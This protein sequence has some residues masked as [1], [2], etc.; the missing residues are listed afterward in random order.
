VLIA[1][2]TVDS[3]NAVGVVWTANRVLT[4]VSN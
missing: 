1:W 2:S 3:T 4:R